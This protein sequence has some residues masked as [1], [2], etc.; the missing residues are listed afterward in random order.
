MRANF[1]LSGVATG[2]RR[3]ATMTIALILST[4]I[5]LAFVGASILANTEIT[6]F[7]HKYE[8]K[9]NVSVYLCARL[10]AN[11]PNCQHKTTAT[12]TS[13]IQDQLRQD[14]LVKSVAY[15]SERDA[16]DR[17]K[18]QQATLAQYIR[19][20][21]L[22]ASFT[23][24]LK[25]VKKDYDAFSAQTGVLPGVGRVNNQ[26]DTI[27]TLLNIIDSARLL[28]IVIALVVLAASILLIANTIQVAATQRKNETSI[29]RL[30][31]A[32][33]WMTE[34]PFVLEAVMAAAVGGL[35][36]FGLIWLGEHYVLDNIF[37]GPTQNGVIPNLGINDV[38]I[39]GG[40]GLI[41]GIGLSAVTAFAT[42]RL[43]VR[44]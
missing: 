16:F 24:K 15:V 11:D 6:K 5:A 7:K 22:P 32:S 38:L 2:I 4:A 41:V 25:N 43:Y 37:A 39:A 1:V 9:I 10:H 34:M 14:P 8:D 33:R 29:M 20:G 36:A 30:V 21:D 12:E 26:I 35:I 44:L 31:G 23:V 28:S 40:T 19:L 42:L 13:A 3:N 27:N 17:G 18:Q